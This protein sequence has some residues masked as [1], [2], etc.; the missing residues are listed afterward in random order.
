MS[1]FRFFS[2]VNTQSVILK[3]RE[4][5]LISEC[6]LLQWRSALRL[7]KVKD[8]LH[9]PNHKMLCVLNVILCRKHKA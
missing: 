1:I 7:K 5:C 4:V 2:V 6:T 8:S 9:M 3:N